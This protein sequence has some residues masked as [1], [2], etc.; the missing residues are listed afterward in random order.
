MNQYILIVACY[1][2]L[3]GIIHPRGLFK[4]E[5][6]LEYHLNIYVLGVLCLLCFASS[7]IL[8]RIFIVKMINYR[9]GIDLHK[10]EKTKVP[11]MGGIVPVSLSALIISIFNP[12]ISS[13]LFISGLI[14]VYDDLYK[15]SPY[16]KLILLGLIGIPIGYLLFGFDIFKIILLV[17]GISISSN[18]T[19]ML[20]GF[21]GL[22][23]GL[24]IISAFFLG[25]ILLLNGDYYGFEIV[26]VFLASYFGFFILNKYPAKVFPGDVGTLPIGAFLA[27]IAVWRSIIPEF[28]IIM[29]PYIIDASLKYYSA[30]ITKREEHK[31]TILGEDG[32]LHVISG[33]L[34]LPRIILKKKPMKE[35]DIAFILWSISIFFGVLAVLF[36]VT[37]I[38]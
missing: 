11:E 4:G 25:I 7:Y 30:G 35:Y 29:M 10:K 38:K 17:L 9:Y 2:S 19:N 5:K 22:E 8:T 33:Y 31:P 28:V 12:L 15:L 37:L 24:G 21:N 34:S 27:T 26:M 20:A 32:K 14:G 36:N 13:V 18:L 23:I 3:I 16:K 6:M 1:K